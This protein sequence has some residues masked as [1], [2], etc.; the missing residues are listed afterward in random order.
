MP[1]CDIAGCEKDAV[2]AI[3]LS[4]HDRA[5]RCPKCLD[6]EGQNEGWW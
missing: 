6:W 2:A 1:E 3:L 4:K 5:A